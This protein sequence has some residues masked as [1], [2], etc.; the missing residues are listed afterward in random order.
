MFVLKGGAQCV[1]YIQMIFSV[2]LE[3]VLGFKVVHSLKYWPMVFYNLLIHSKSLN[4]TLTTEVKALNWNFC[5]IKVTLKPIQC[6]KSLSRTSTD[7][8]RNNSIYKILS[9]PKKYLI[10]YTAKYI[11]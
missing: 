2:T 3:R 11:K 6:T 9:H 4:L 8:Q 5:V 10:E 1:K 7:F